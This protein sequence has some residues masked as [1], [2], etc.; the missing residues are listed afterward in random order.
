MTQF[1][2]LIAMLLFLVSSTAFAQTS[3]RVVIDEFQLSRW[4]TD[5]MQA[6]NIPSITV[7]VVGP[8][9]NYYLQ[10]FGPA[11][12]DDPFLIGSLSKS[13]TALAVMLLVHDGVIGLDD[14]ASKWVGGIPDAVTVRHLLHQRSG[15]DRSSG[16][17]AWTDVGATLSDEI[18]ST[19]FG[20]PGTYEYS[21]LNYNILGGIVARASGKPYA[22]F[23]QQRIFT[24]A[25]MTTASA[26]PTPPAARVKG[27]QYM[28]GFPVDFGEPN[29]NPIAVPSGFVWMSANDMTRYIRLFVA[30]GQLDGQQVVPADVVEQLLTK[31]DS[32]SYAMGWTVNTDGPVPVANHNGA[33][34]AFTSAMAVVGDREFGVFVLTNLNLW[35]A[36]GTTNILNG[37][38]SPILGTEPQSVTNIEFVVRLGFGFVVALILFTFL[39]ELVR[40]L[41]SRFPLRLVP[42][43]RN[44]VLLTAAINIAVVVA[45]TF[46]WET[47]ILAIVKTQPDIGL[48]FLVAVGIGTLRRLLTGFNK[49]AHERALTGDDN[50][51]A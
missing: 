39:F 26:Q 22:D 11:E 34:A 28:Y 51:E 13:V 35:M 40:W 48:G 29:Y 17:T 12:L 27:H 3:S 31:P 21:N 16:G 2:Y 20:S 14:P 30:K 23:V 8:K 45:V 46:Y 37:V 33:T 25:K 50:E 47:S 41:N 44:A 19:T 9:E 15:L 32:G 18:A 4:V 43:E 49:S 10:S 38:L 5:N 36:L 1:R 6:L 42:R 24:P 7:G